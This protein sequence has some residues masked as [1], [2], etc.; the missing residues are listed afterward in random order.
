M[1]SISVIFSLLLFLRTVIFI[2]TFAN[3]DYLISKFALYI[4][5]SFIQSW[6]KER[7]EKILRLAVAYI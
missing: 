3:K 2:V 6:Q 4:L 1:F 5:V 7:K